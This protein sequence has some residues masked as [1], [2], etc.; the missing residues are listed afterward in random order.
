[1]DGRE[2]QVAQRLRARADDHEMPAGL[3]ERSLA[4]AAR[5]RRRRRAGLAL[6]SGAAVVAVTT[7]ALLVPTVGARQGSSP[8]APAGWDAPATAPTTAGLDDPELARVLGRD[9]VSVLPREQGWFDLRAVDLAGD[10]TLV[11]LEQHHDARWFDTVGDVQVLAL[12]SA[13][14][15]RVEPTVDGTSTSRVA[16]ADADQVL[17]LEHLDPTRRFDLVCTPWVGGSRRVLS[18]AGVVESSVVVD[19][20]VVVWSTYPSEDADTYR[21]WAAAGCDGEPRELA[22]A[23]VVAAV[24]WPEVYLQTATTAWFARVDARTGAVVELP[25][26]DL[27]ADDLP[28]AV[29]ERD[30]LVVAASQDVLAWA[31]GDRLLATDLTTG[32]AWVV[33]DD[34]PVVAGHG[35]TEVRVGVGDHLLTWSSSPVDGDP[36]RSRGVVVDLRTEDSASVPGEV[37]ASG[38]WLVWLDEDGYRFVSTGR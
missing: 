24:A 21:T 20:G 19:D 30:G 35:G 7:L 18:Q 4:A 36:R 27:R 31:V 15:R 29:G 22:V 9:S 2:V 37:L 11:A 10:G 12:P 3:V 6:S 38:S 25:V 5:R 8:A 17:T 26:P 14:A 33:A 1:M 34:L 16:A 28:G 23:G 32:R 13:A